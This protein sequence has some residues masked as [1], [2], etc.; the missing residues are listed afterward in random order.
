MQL[1][2]ESVNEILW[3][4]HSNETS[5]AVLLYGAIYFSI[6]YKIKFGIF[7]EFRCFALFGVKGLKELRCTSVQCLPWGDDVFRSQLPQIKTKYSGC[8]SVIHVMLIEH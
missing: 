5:S 8:T 1:T 7:F 6:F 2:F 4:D 3:C